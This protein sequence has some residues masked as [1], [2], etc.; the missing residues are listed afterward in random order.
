MRNYYNIFEIIPITDSENNIICKSLPHIKLWGR[1]LFKKTRVIDEIPF[2]YSI[3]DSPSSIPQFSVDVCLDSIA[4]KTTKYTQ[5]KRRKIIMMN[6]NNEF[7]RM[8]LGNFGLKGLK[9]QL[10]VK[11]VEYYTN[12]VKNHFGIEI[13][14]TE[15]AQVDDITSWISKYD[16]KFKY[17]IANPTNTFKQS[18][19]RIDKAFVLRLDKA[20]YAFISG[21]V[22]RSGNDRGE[23]ATLY[24][25]LFGKKYRK[26]LAKISKYLKDQVIANSMMYSIAAVNNADRGSSYWTCTG[27]Q[28]TPRPMD[29]LYFSKGVKED[30]I[31]HLDKWEANEKIYKERGLIFKTG[32]LLYGTPG[33]GKSSLASAIANYMNCALITIDMSTFADLNIAEVTESINADEDRYVILMDEIDTIF[34]SREDDDA[35]DKQRTVI[36]KLLQFMDSQHSPTN[37]IFVATTNYRDR[38][39]DALLRKGRFDKMIELN[40]I[41]YHAAVAMCKGFNLN[42]EQIDSIGLDP[43]AKV[44]PSELQDTILSIIAHK[45]NIEEGD[46]S[47]EE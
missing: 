33:T 46:D 14:F 42:Q 12:R 41:D 3:D 6:M 10:M 8:M 28:L 16:P 17:H 1:S 7:E 13:R 25:Y 45:A 29:T 39:D 35:T 34:S 18:K 31:S 4:N 40:N 47:I 38:L 32:I 23:V 26:W 24:M 9:N 44:N 22:M 15:M 19:P 21:E 37:V 2:M 30:I 20:T 43:N 11:G 5:R 36:S 27:S